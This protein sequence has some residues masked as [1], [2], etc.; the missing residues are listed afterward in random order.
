MEQT[1]EEKLKGLYHLQRIYSKLF[2]DRDPDNPA[3]VEKLLHLLD[4][5]FGEWKMMAVHYLWEDLFWQH[6]HQPVDW[7]EALI[8]L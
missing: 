5:R 7:L 8:R 4:A 2:L 1:V 3:P 6:V